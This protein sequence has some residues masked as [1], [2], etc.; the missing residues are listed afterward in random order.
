MNSYKR[1]VKDDIIVD[2]VRKN[3]R[4]I[5]VRMGG[6]IRALTPEDFDKL[7]EQAPSSEEKFLLDLMINTGM[8]YVELQRYIKSTGDIK[9]I[10]GIKDIKSGWFDYKRNKIVLPSNATKTFETRNVLL[11]PRFTD[12]LKRELERKN[13]EMPIISYQ[14]L[15]NRLKKWAIKGDIDKP[16]IIAVKTFRKS[17]E[18]WLV[19]AD[20]NVLKVLASQGHRSTIALDH[21]L[22][23][24]FTSEEKEE[25]IKRTEGW[26]E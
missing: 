3:R 1:K 25:M 13:T 21:Y 2:K 5:K 8:R 19:S 15:D 9:I 18:S 11:T 17:W 12:I 23:Y 24:G 7:R 6:E 10:K 4:D 20:K 26:G 16:H 22:T 14:T